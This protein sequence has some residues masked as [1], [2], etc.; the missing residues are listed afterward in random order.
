VSVE[1]WR[2]DGV[3]AI[4][5]C[6]EQA[7]KKPQGAR[8]CGREGKGLPED[9]QIRPEAHAATATALKAPRPPLTSTVVAAVWFA[10]DI[11]RLLSIG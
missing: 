9:G 4:Y 11:V 8:S 7:N 1:T 10:D 2:R 3:V 6:L 5:G